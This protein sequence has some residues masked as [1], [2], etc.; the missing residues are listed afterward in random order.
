MKKTETIDLIKGTFTP[1]DARE[2][3]LSLLNSKIKFHQLKDWSSRERFGT[4]DAESE[5]RLKSLKDARSKTET[6]LSTLISK[7]NNEK[8][9]TLNST[10]EIII[11]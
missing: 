11:E 4:P 1:R 3:L 9:V 2:V 8:S 6:L 5:Q 7:D 10:I